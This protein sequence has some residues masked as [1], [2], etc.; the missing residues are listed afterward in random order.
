MIDHSAIEMRRSAK[1]PTLKSL[2]R[3]SR[4]LKILSGAIF[5]AYL[6]ILPLYTQTQMGVAQYVDTFIGIDNGGDTIP[7]PS[8]PFG[9][10]KPGPDT[11][12][13]EE[14]SGWGPKG[15]I[16]GFSQTHVSGT[17]GGDS[18]G[19][20]LIQPTSGDPQ[21]SHIESARDEEHGSIGFYGVLL[22]R[23]GIHVEIT[24]AARASFYRFTY[25]RAKKANIL[26]DAGHCL[27]S[28]E[29][30]GENQSITS[31]S[32]HVISP[33]EVSGFSSV[34]GGWNKQPV[35][36]TVYF[37]A[38]TDTPA[39]SW[40]TWRDGKMHPGNK[41]EAPGDEDHTGAWL[42]FKASYQQQVNVKIGISF[43]SV[44]QAKQ[45]VL[46]EIPGFNFEQVHEV[47]VRAWDQALGKVQI[48]GATPQQ[49]Q[50]F[51]TAL[52]HSMLMPVDRTGENP[53]W[54]SSEPYYDDFYTIWDTFRATNPLLTLIDEQREID[55]VRSLVDMYRHEGWMPDGR[56]GNYN[57][58]VQGGSDAD[59][60]LADAYAKG[61]KGIDWPTAYKAL[62]NDAENTPDD[63]FKEGRG[64]LEDWHKLGYL[65]IEGT[66]R[67]GSKQVEYAA[68]DFAV[69]TVAKGLGKTADYEKYLKRSGNWQNLWDSDFEDNG[70]KGFIRPRHRDGSWLTPFSANESASFYGDTFYEG[71][72]WTYSL[73]VPQD[74]SALMDKCGG[75]DRFVARLDTFFNGEFDVTNEPGFLT[76]Y[77]YNWAERPDKAAERVRDILTKDFHPGRGGLPGNDDSG[78]MSGW[79]AFNVM[80]IFPNAGQDVY[81]IGSPLYRRTVITMDNGRTFTIE[82]DNTSSENK[83]V[84]AA[85]LN[86]K[87]L[88]QDW[89]RHTDIS[90]GGQLVLTM[91]NKPGAWPTG[92]PPPSAGR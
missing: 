73:Y 8:L 55:I 74:V 4:L 27:S 23:Y 82:A 17:G 28:G 59:M 92:N 78:A 75:K 35:P 88:N 20:I 43:V 69:A 7:G 45:N 76:P 1:F 13:N 64:D 38:I 9:M 85:S 47:A 46:K 53:L 44:E 48:E 10:V 83:Y 58:R 29:D 80:G 33:T 2:E 49:R 86:G 65:T 89:F 54:K 62:V 68:N 77:L 61:L 24:T 87:P 60:V 32:I 14:D 56:Q 5:F 34:K 21:S 3:N 71:N 37:Y 11:G 30:W 50:L 90:N 63:P 26:F 40:G 16:N 41:V 19:N 52:Y 6:S 22:L 25:A 36:Y 57:G 39:T 51:Y 81:L 66:D 84:V 12:T 91:A 67:P 31:S 42:S 15:A 18:Y 70:F 79:Y 72:T